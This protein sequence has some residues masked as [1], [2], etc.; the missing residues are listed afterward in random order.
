M[1]HEHVYTK[2]AKG[3][4]EIRNRASALDRDLRP[5]LGAIDGR[6]TAQD[7]AVRLGL[8]EDRVQGALAQLET[9]GYVKPVLPATE[10]DLDFTSPVAMSRL[11]AEAE[12]RLRA[13]TAAQA[14]AAE[15]ARAA[16]AAQARENDQAR[17]QA[18]AEAQALQAAQARAQ[19]EA[20]ARKADSERAQAA[21]DASTARTPQMKAQAQAR[22]EAALVS[23]AR[24]AAEARMRAQAE[25]TARTAIA[26]SAA[27][28]AQA[29][30]ESQAR[31]RAESEARA[32]AHAEAHARAMIEA[33]LK[34]MSAALAR[35]QTLAREEAEA[36]ERVTADLQ[37]RDAMEAQTRAAAAAAARAEA[38]TAMRAE[39]MQM[40]EEAQRA[41]EA[42][43]ARANAERMAREAAE[44]LA[45][46]EREARAAAEAQA[47]AEREAREAA[48]LAAA[49][50]AEARARAE[51]AAL[52]EAQRRAHGA[53]RAATQ[54]RVDAE[55]EARVAAESRAQA[56]ADARLAHEAQVR[57]RSESELQQRLSQELAAR[58][59]AERLADAQYRAAAAQRAKEAAE[60]RPRRPLRFLPRIRF[61]VRA[62]A[63]AGA[64]AIVVLLA[65]AALLLPLVPLDRYVRTAERAIGDITQQPVHLGKAQYRLLPTPQLTLDRVAIGQ[66]QQ[67]RIERM[68]VTAWPWELYAQPLHLDRVLAQDV[69]LDQEGLAVLRAMS[70]KPAADR[71]HVD[72]LVLEGVR[73]TIQDVD[74]AITSATLRYTQDA[75]MG[76]AAIVTGNARLDF[77]RAAMGWQMTLSARNWQLPIGSTLEFEELAVQG[78]VDDGRLRHARITG[79]VAGG[80]LAGTVQADWRSGIR[81]EGEFELTK[82]QLQRILPAYTSHFSADGILSLRGQYVLNAPTLGKVAQAPRVTADFALSD[83]EL[84]N[85]DLVRALQT[86]ASRGVQ[87]GRTRFDELAGRVE[88]S[89]ERYRYR[90]LKLV[91]GPLTATGDL[92]LASDDR[93]AGRISAEVTSATRPPFRAAVA[94]AGTLSN[95]VL[96]P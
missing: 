92:E 80:D 15:A 32:R 94:V 78:I 73:A 39:L 88:I 43:E 81:A 60:H 14:R 26:A 55:R 62:V 22:M 19:A 12:A 53:E 51:S 31:A 44:A 20:A 79:R 75:G 59:E 70:G 35:A 83:G 17:A 71:A 56:E 27:A 66:L 86:V 9:G 10:E 36:R 54:A 82:A 72:T 30:E 46:G 37:A 6:S 18:A 57:E 50:D 93:L 68:I 8:P 11:Q 3:L 28:A 52:L 69:K 5:V 21:M 65:A 49:Q 85:V 4:L 1:P 89:G 95:P 40:R 33:Q 87:G 7:V 24:A 77:S 63:V 47:L 90:Q 61:D 2:T 34:A 91:S 67:T 42:V 25:A 29:R 23:E 48:V 58:V 96:R 38:E 84:A 74:L 41:R 64:G 13:E 45:A 76:S 16:A